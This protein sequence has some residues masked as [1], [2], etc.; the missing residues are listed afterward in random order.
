MVIQNGQIVQ[1]NLRSLRL[2]VD[3][4]ENM[5]RQKGIS[6][7]SDVK[8]ATLEP[9]GQIGYELMQHAKPI[10]VGELERI[11]GLKS[12]TTMEQNTIFQEV[13]QNHNPTPID[14]KLQ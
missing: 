2:T 12:G 13:I 5:L 7:I 3:Q 11:L 6:N 1:E 10:T 8:T 4:L 9:N 14:P